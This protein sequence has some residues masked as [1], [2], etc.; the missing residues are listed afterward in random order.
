MHRLGRSTLRARTSITPS[1]YYI[2]A[3]LNGSIASP[4]NTTISD[5]G[6]GGTVDGVIDWSLGT[7][8]RFHTPPATDGMRDDLAQLISYWLNNGDSHVHT[9][10]GEST[11][12]RA[13][14]RFPTGFVATA[15][16]WNWLVVWHNQSAVVPGSVSIALGMKSDGTIP[17]PGTNPRLIFR[18]SG[19]PNT[20]P[21]YHWYYANSTIS[22]DHWYDL[23]FNIT[24]GTT[25]GDGRASFWVDAATFDATGQTGEGAFTNPVSH[26]TLFYN[27][28]TLVRDQPGFGVY[29]YHYDVNFNYDIDWDDIYI[30]PTAASVGFSP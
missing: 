5:A 28:S 24:W 17:G 23:V 18:P 20:A 27:S 8:V 25:S 9:G 15:G 29:N 14:L 12:Y 7:A 4:W 3:P 13:K 2:Y 11:W 26:P 16:T 10:E 30:G 22:T 21:E 6:F 19:G 1:D